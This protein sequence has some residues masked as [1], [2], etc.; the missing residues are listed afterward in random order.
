MRYRWRRQGMPYR[1]L[2]LIGLRRRLLA[3]YIAHPSHR[4]ALVALHKTSLR[5]GSDVDPLR[6]RACQTGEDV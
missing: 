5:S 3:A 6:V 1:N 4:N 2:L